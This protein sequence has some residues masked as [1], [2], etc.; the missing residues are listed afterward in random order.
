[1]EVHKPIPVNLNQPYLGW[2]GG[3][4]Y[5]ESLRAAL[6]TLESNGI[7]TVR[8]FDSSRYSEKYLSRKIL[9][10]W[11]RFALSSTVRLLGRDELTL[12][13]PARFSGSKSL[14]WI[15]D[16]QDLEHPEFFS[17]K[18]LSSR[19]RFRVRQIDQGNPLYF[20]SYHSKKVFESFFDMDYHIAGIVRF[21]F[22]TPPSQLSTGNPILDCN[23]CRDLGFLYVPNQWW[24]HKNHL[25]LFDA[26]K[27]YVSNGGQ[28]HLVLTGEERDPRFPL[29]A[30]V[31]KA[32]ISQSNA[33]HALGLVD[34]D[35]QMQ[36]MRDAT[37]YVQPSIYEGWSTSIEEALYFGTPILA[38]K[39]PV[40]Q[41][42]TEGEKDCGLFSITE[43]D[44]LVYRLFNPP[45]RNTLDEVERRRDQRWFRFID[46]LHKVILSAH[47]N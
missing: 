5:L 29:L 43:I 12:P 44:D 31:I 45:I 19:Q 30:E 39:I 34:R 33:I 24:T 27:K 18:E 28:L 1:L 46:D 3:N 14:V 42:Q 47:Q 15:P 41:E 38:S 20:S 11:S 13:F 35:H 22:S 7:L 23:H 25:F 32:R 10:F 40:L 4:R 37:V 2:E 16:L 36:L 9:N 17:A 26:Y 6:K 21:S 8:S